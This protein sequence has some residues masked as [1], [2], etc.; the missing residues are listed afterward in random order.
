MFVYSVKDKIKI[1]RIP[2]Q[3]QVLEVF[4]FMGVFR[5]VYQLVDYL[6]WIQEDGGSNPLLPTTSKFSPLLASETVCKTVAF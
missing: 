5:E 2:P 3:R 6:I 4:C 1:F